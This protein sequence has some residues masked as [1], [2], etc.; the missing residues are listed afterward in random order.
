VDAPRLTVGMTLYNVEHY[1]PLALDALLAQDFTD[2]ELVACDNASSDRTWDIVTRYAARDPRIRPYRNE[3]N[4]GQ[5]G[6]FRRVVELARGEL[7][8]L[9]SHDDLPAPGMV[10]RCVGALDEAGPRTVLAYPQTRIISADGSDLGAWSDE[11]ELR[12]P[13]AWL[14]VA[15]WAARWHLCNELFG[16]MRT[17]TLRRTHLLVDSVVSPD[18]LLL[19]ELAMHGRFRQVPE[20]L[21]FRRM[22]PAGTHQGE[23][24]LAEVAAYLEPQAQQRQVKT[25]YALTREVARRLPDGEVSTVTGHACAAAFTARY[26]L[27]RVQGR[28]RRFGERHLRVP[29]TPPAPW[30]A[31]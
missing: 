1:L 22:H 16:V 26:G 9:Q 30:E 12:A 29:H 4:L 3:T 23:R 5:A 19:A 13:W 2:F 21:F 28:L 7:F 18:V 10:G 24:T 11:G 27:R 31:V 8:K 17:D 15:R 14:R 20:E 6:N 25:K